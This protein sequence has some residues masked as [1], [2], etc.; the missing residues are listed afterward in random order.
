M[1]LVKESNKISKR[2]VTT[3]CDKKDRCHI[4]AE[5]ENDLIG[6]DGYQFLV[7][8]G[9]TYGGYLNV[10]LRPGHNY[11]VHIAVNVWL[12]KVIGMTIRL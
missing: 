12:P 10:P 3:E 6:E 2:S 5:I 4:A 8:D 11:S 9:K 7:G 1:V